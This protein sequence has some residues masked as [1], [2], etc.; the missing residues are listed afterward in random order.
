MA[1]ADPS[2]FPEEVLYTHVMTLKRA[3]IDP[4][5]SFQLFIG[6]DDFSRTFFS[7]VPPEWSML[8]IY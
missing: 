7:R 3:I 8:C 6:M 4:E 1:S 5:Q 2:F